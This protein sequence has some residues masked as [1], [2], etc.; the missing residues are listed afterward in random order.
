MAAPSSKLAGASTDTT[1]TKTKPVVQR[2]AFSVAETALSLGLSRAKVYQLMGE[3]K[4]G[5]VQVGSRRL[6]PLSALQAFLT[7]GA[8]W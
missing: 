1:D 3:H 6:V 7:P 8:R 4:L 2:T 5:F